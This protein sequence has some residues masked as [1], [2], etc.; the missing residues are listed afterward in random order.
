MRKVLLLVMIGLMAAALVLTPL[1]LTPALALGG[2]PGS[3][4]QTLQ[5]QKLPASLA[6]AVSAPS[7]TVA[8]LAR[9]PPTTAANKWAVVIG[10]A[11]YTGTGNDLWHPDEDATEMAK[12]LTANYGFATDHVKILLNSK[13]TA[14]A[15]TSAI[16]WLVANENSQSTVVFFYSGHGFNAPD[17]DAWDTDIEADGNDEGIVSYD[18]YGLPD[19]W[20]AQRLAGLE[21]QKIA[22]LFGSCNS[23]GLFDAANELQGANRVIAAA[24]KADQYGW[25]YLNLGNTLWGKY[26]VDEGILQKAADLDSNGVSIEEAHD[27]AYPKV[28]AVQ[29]GSQP[30]ISDN[31]QGDFIP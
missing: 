24:C 13:A 9:K 18:L 23:G 7:G 29:S 12:A 15:I 31:Y 4:G 5:I 17:A 19:S 20:L 10:I 26:F 28:V 6:K 27:Y 16:S 25:D 21:S 22:M 8:P 1:T 30:Q 11:N 14:S 3:I 2:R